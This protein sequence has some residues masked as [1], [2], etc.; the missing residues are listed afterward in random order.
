MIFAVFVGTGG[1][2]SLAF[3]HRLSAIGFLSWGE[4]NCD[5]FC[6]VVRFNEVRIL[7]ECWVGLGRRVEVGTEP[8]CEPF[9][10]LL[11]HPRGQ[12]RCPG[13]IGMLRAR[14][15]EFHHQYIGY[16]IRG[17]STRGLRI[18]SD[19]GRWV[20]AGGMSGRLFTDKLVFRRLE[21]LG[22]W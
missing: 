21:V 15:A 14:S 11:E 6:W 4:E 18:L 2:R 1:D 8:C 19:R 13:L 16:E 7:G 22:A 10:A 17:L 20:G 9:W 5:A 12:V 3:G